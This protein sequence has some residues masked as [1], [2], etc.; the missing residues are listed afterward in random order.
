MRMRQ[1]A[2]SRSSAVSQ[3]ANLENVIIGH[4]F[5][6][7]HSPA[8]FIGSFN[9]ALV[10]RYGAL[11]QASLGNGLARALIARFVTHP[12]HSLNLVCARWPSHCRKPTRLSVS[13]G[14]Y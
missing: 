11:P 9:V 8:Q 7:L 10:W 6:L 3:A 13:T 14:S 12:C 4:Y 1:T 2:N 5:H